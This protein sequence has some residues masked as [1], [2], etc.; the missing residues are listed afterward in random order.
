MPIIFS[1]FR[2]FV[3]FFMTTLGDDTRH[4]IHHRYR[5]GVKAIKRRVISCYVEYGEKRI[6]NSKI[7]PP[8]PV[9][10]IVFDVGFFFSGKKEKKKNN[11]NIRNWTKVFPF[12]RFGYF[13]ILKKNKKHR[14]IQER[15]KDVREIMKSF[16]QTW[17]VKIFYTCEFE[18]GFVKVFRTYGLNCYESKNRKF[19][20]EK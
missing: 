18:L 17:I 4:S 3:L 19:H 6:L 8:S 20:Y 14:Q 10:S 12:D 1:L 9:Y 2:I 16:L 7:I 11:K 5:K 13:S 15:I